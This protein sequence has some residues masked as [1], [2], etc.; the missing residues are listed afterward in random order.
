MYVQWGGCNPSSTHQFCLCN[1][2]DDPKKTGHLLSLDGAKERLHLFKAGLLEEGAFDAVID[3]CVCV[4]HTASPVQLSATDPQAEIVEP[5][6]K[7]TLNVLKSCVKFPTV[8]R[9]VLTSSMSSSSHSRTPITSEMVLDET[10]RS[11]PLVCG[12]NRVGTLPILIH[13][14]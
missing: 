8:K 10:W 2:T 12:Q 3:G 13:K 11:D 9:V 1:A 6:V 4:F 14:Q 5:A 7:G